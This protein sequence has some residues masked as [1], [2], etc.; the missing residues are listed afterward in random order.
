MDLLDETSH[1]K[2]QYKAT[3]FEE[4]RMTPFLI[5]LTGLLVLLIH[6]VCV[7]IWNMFEWGDTDLFPNADL[8]KSKNDLVNSFLFAPRY[9][10]KVYEVIDWHKYD[11]YGARWLTVRHFEF[12]IG[13]LLVGFL[14][15]VVLFFAAR[16]GM[17][18][19][20]YHVWRGLSVIYLGYWA[21]VSLYMLSQYVSGITLYRGII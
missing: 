14:A 6:S 5:A 4:N 11:S 18:I 13:H 20:R 7:F 3:K 21:L 1:S 8:W 9:I 15:F 12:G 19:N 2:S 10:F 17:K 16:P